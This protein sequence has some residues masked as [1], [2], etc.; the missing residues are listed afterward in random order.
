MR[1]HVE[2]TGSFIANDGRGNPHWLLV[3]TEYIDV[4]ATRKSGPQMKEGP[5]TIRTTEGKH[6]DRLEL[7]EYKV[8]ETGVRLTSDDPDAP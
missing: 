8:V 1:S 6:V 5:T 4:P 2:Q 7:G 3:F